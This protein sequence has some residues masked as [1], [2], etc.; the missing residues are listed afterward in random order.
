MEQLE[1]KK[2]CEEEYSVPKCIA[3]VDAMEELTDEQKADANEL[4]QSEMNRQIFVST[5]NPRVRL[6]W[7]KKKIG[8]VCFR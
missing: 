7:L 5:T 3:I 6:I 1:E 2:R 4:F 8:Q